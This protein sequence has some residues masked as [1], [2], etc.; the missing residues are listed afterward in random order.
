MHRA[1]LGHQCHLVIQF[2]MSRAAGYISVQFAQS[3][4]ICY[5]IVCLP[6]ICDSPQRQ[7]SDCG[8]QERSSTGRRY[9]ALLQVTTAWPWSFTYLLN[10]LWII[11]MC[12]PVLTY[13][14][15][16]PLPQCWAKQRGVYTRRRTC[17]RFWNLSFKLV[18][19][20]LGRNGN[21][22]TVTLTSG[23]SIWK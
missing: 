18:V 19:C 16:H 12:D 11:T 6:V 4:V 17:C 20:G 15:L 2:K 23:G 7:A 9:F 10:T 1:A 14:E 3:D 5:S 8:R 22:F 21:F 13:P